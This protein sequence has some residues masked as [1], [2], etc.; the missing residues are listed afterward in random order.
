MYARHMTF[1]FSDEAALLGVPFEVAAG[2]TSDSGGEAVE[3]AVA[4]RFTLPNPPDGILVGSTTAAMAA[5]AGAERAGMSLAAT[6]TWWPKRRSLSC[7][8]SD[9][10]S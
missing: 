5:I 1:G 6:L 9:R 10:T 7:A 2:V 4:A 8:A 3:A